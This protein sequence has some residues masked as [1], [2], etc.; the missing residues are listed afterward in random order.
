MR[1]LTSRQKKVLN[2]IYKSYKP[3]NWHDLHT[4]DIEKLEQINN[5]EILYQEV[6]RYLHDLQW[7]VS[8]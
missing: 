8:K 4:E 5:T 2:E 6:N 7:G 3:L 1:Q